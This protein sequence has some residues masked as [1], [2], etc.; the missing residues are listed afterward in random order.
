MAHCQGV[1]GQPS[2]LARE[3][4]WFLLAQHSFPFGPGKCGTPLC[5]AEAPDCHMQCHCGFFEVIVLLSL[6]LMTYNARLNLI[7][8]ELC[9][10]LS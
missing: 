8:M 3:Q 4:T 9:Q 5:S 10:T 6:V 2:S 1:K 7:A